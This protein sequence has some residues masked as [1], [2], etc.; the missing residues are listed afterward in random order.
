MKDEWQSNLGLG[1]LQM[2]YVFCRDIHL[3]TAGRT[4]MVASGRC[5]ARSEYEHEVVDS[6][7]ACGLGDLQFATHQ[8][9][10]AWS[11]HEIT[12]KC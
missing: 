12:R 3:R 5:R 11:G 10:G 1:Q 6:S 9:S 7:V 2:V 4:L 8:I